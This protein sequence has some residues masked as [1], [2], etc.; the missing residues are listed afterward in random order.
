MKSKSSEDHDFPEAIKCS[1]LDADKKIVGWNRRRGK[2]SAMPISMDQ[3]QTVLDAYN[4]QLRAKGRHQAKEK[5]EIL[6]NPSV[7]RH[8]SRWMEHIG[9]KAV[10]AYKNVTYESLKGLRPAMENND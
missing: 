4:R 9:D 10:A 1:D 8:R 3:V 6:M 7:T 2:D 5:T